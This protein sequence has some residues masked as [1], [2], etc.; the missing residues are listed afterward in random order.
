MSARPALATHR[1]LPPIARTRKQIPPTSVCTRGAA[2]AR[3]QSHS[4]QCPPTWREL[5]PESACFLG[6]PPP[7]PRDST[8]SL[9]RSKLVVSLLRSVHLGCGNERIVPSIHDQLGRLSSHE[10]RLR[11]VPRTGGFA[12]L[13]MCR[14]SLS[15]VRSPHLDRVTSRHNCL[16]TGLV[17]CRRRPLTMPRAAC[18]ATLQQH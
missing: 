7:N 17:R 16:G 6:L 15:F 10:S 3:L 12:T 9:P 1:S 13:R 11:H 8:R 5:L 2:S 4:P 18:A 14:V